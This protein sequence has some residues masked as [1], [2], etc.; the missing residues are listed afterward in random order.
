MKR[1][2]RVAAQK[3]G[4][5]AAPSVP[6]RHMSSVY[7]PPPVQITT[8]PNKIRVA[9]EATPGHF[10]ALG[11]YVDAGSRYES[12]RFS[13]CS[14]ILDR[15]AWKSTL[16]QPGDAVSAQIDALGGQFLCSSSRETIMYQASHFPHDAPAALGIIA[17]TIQ[18]SLFLPEEL[19]AQRDAAAY[20]VREVSAK[21]EMI[22]PEIIHTVAYRDN[23]L[24]NPLLCPEDR[25]DKIDGPLLR[26][27]MRTWFRPERMV[28]AGAGMPHQELVE[29]AQRYFGDMA[30]PTA[31]SQKVPTYL[32]N[33]QGLKSQP[34]LYKSL[35]TA[36][37]SFMHNSAEPSFNNLANA[38]ARYTGG[39]L[40]LPRPDL[41][42]T[43]LYVAFEGVPIHDPDVYALATMQILLGG[44]GSFS[45]GG[46]GKGM[47]SRL[48]THILNHHP[49]IDHCAAFHHIYTDSSLF[50]I[51]TMLHLST[52]PTQVLPIIAHQ[53][54]MLLY[55]N[56]PAAE[57]QRAKNQ[58]KSS[59]VMA[60]E[61][62]AV[63]VEDLGRQVLVHGRK[64]GVEEMCE[65]ID[66][67]DAADMRRVAGRV[68]GESGS[69][70][71]VVVMGRETVQ[72][73]ERVLAS[74]GVGR[75]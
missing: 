29:L 75:T 56:V 36:A 33:G 59:L 26:E 38:R 62:R 9:T 73:P 25:I 21:P 45:A 43:H 53:F 58:L 64:I 71:T 27:F 54:A 3:A 49:Q 5:R 31:A 67:I 44:G 66:K 61:S 8:L 24:G 19:D 23:T 68:F 65:K 35:T 12:P 32:L 40:F 74:Y 42:L 13:G 18:H 2:L 7:V 72:E 37:T 10:G 51:N 39:Y 69:R 6:S 16:T 52:S 4:R 14:H 47:Y 55:K 1:T 20:E 11:I 63:E 57:L 30:L 41:E 50:G 34:S 46:P 22:L 70:A 48:Y 28:V 15:M 17:D 60:L